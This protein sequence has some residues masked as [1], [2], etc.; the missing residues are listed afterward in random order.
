MPQKLCFPWNCQ[1]PLHHT[2]LVESIDV[3]TTNTGNRVRTV[4]IVDTLS[5]YA[6]TLFQLIGSYE[7]QELSTY[8]SMRVKLYAP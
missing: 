7:D 8:K 3:S 5:D 4:G 2:D 1:Y 6:N